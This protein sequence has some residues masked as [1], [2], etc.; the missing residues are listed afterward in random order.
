METN[1]KDSLTEEEIQSGL[2]AVILDGLTTQT[3]T[4]LAGGIFLTAFA[5]QLGAS[6]LVIGFLAAIPALGQLVQIP[7]IYLVEKLRARRRITVSSAAASR[8]LLLFIAL[9]PFMFQ[10]QAALY[11][12]LLSLIFMSVFAGV[13]GCSWNSWMRD[14]IPQDRL[15]K[16]FSKRMSL[17]A[18]LGIVLILAAGIYI[19]YWKKLLPHYVLYGYS[20]LFFLGFLAGMLGVYF[21]STIPEPRMPPKKGKVNLFRVLSKPFKDPNFKNLFVF[22]GSWNFAVNLAAPFFTVYMLKRLQLDM[23]FII[24]LMVIAQIMNLLFLRIWGR[25][26]DRFSNKSVLAVSGPLFM[27]C[28]L[29]WVFTTLPGKHLLTIPILL[30]IHVFAGV[31]N[32]GVT[33]ASGNIGLKLAPKGDATSYLAA[34]SIVNS[35]SA[36][37]APIIGGKFA[38]FF[39]GRE[40]SLTLR[41]VSPIRFLE[42]QTLNLQQWDFFFFLAFIIGLYSIHRLTMV[43]EVGEVEEEIVINELVSEIKKP[44]LNFSTVGGLRQTVYFPFAMLKKLP[45]GRKKLF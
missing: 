24:V 32:A 44:L 22:S 28:I 36:G 25:F 41:W 30:G 9:L 3:M 11:P 13:A 12:F 31:S 37:I 40:L 26:T 17:A 15:G 33:I 16:F 21:I 1:I 18:A 38:D 8:I 19:D 34:N 27:F 35:L 42:F 45:R 10:T 23:S 4:T 2:R 29:A 20:I 14:L 43:K 39:A 7:S 5:L 6:N